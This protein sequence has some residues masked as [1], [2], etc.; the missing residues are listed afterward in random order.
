[1]F[2]GCNWL[3]PKIGFLDVVLFA[4]QVLSSPRPPYFPKADFE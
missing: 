4:P 2:E 3:I 1:M